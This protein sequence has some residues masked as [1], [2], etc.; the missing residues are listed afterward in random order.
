M[1]D[2]GPVTHVEQQILTA[3]F[4]DENIVTAK[5]IMR[6][7]FAYFFLFVGV[8]YSRGMLLLISGFPF[9]FL[10]VQVR[11]IVDCLPHVRIGIQRNIHLLFARRPP[12]MCTI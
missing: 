4:C 2:Y 1:Q 6:P 10:L 8:S 7:G 11:T 3:E 9:G 5:D 12:S